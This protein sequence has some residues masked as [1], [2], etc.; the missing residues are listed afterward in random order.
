MIQKARQLIALAS[1][2]PL[3]VNARFF[4]KEAPKKDG[5]KDDKAAAPAAAVEE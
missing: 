3:N 5:K 4:A 1:R 2:T